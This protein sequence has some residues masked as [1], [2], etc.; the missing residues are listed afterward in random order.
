MIDLKEMYDKAIQE[1]RQFVLTEEMLNVGIKQIDKTIQSI[2]D[3]VMVHKTSYFP[4]KAIKTP[5]D[6]KKFAMKTINCKMVKI[7]SIN[8]QLGVIEILFIFV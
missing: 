8:I 1:G 7:G 4:N 5:F 2:D 6:T 3:L